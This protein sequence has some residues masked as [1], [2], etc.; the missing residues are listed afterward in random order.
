MADFCDARL[1]VQKKRELPW[2]PSDERKIL[3]VEGRFL[4]DPTR[5]GHRRNRPQ[6]CWEKHAAQSTVTHHGAHNAPGG[7]LWQRRIAARGGNGVSSRTE[8]LREF[9]HEQKNPRNTPIP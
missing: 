8:R 7:S 9:L 1:S 4:R 5:R 6:W 2:R 3:G